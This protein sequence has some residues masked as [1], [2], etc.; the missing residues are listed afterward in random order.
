MSK[1]VLVTGHRG[2]VGRHLTRALRARGDTVVGI[3]LRAGHDAVSFFRTDCPMGTGLAGEVREPGWGA[4]K[5]TK[6]DVVVHL[7][8]LVG[9]RATIEGTPGELAARDLQLDASMFRWALALP[10]NRRPGRIVYP[11]SSAA[12]PIELQDPVK[13]PGRELSECDIELDRAREPDMSYG[14]VKLTGER[15]ANWVRTEGVPV[16]V[17]R[18][19]SGYGG[20]QDLDYPFPSFIA[21]ALRREDPF[22]VWGSGQQVRDWIHIQDVTRQLVACVDGAVPD[23]VHAVNLCTGRATTFLELA[24]LVT[25]RAGYSPQVLP[26]TYKPTGPSNRVGDPRLMRRYL[27]EPEVSLEEGIDLALRGRNDH[28]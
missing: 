13:F 21:R 20:D 22:E 6:F 8:A 4:R 23:D 28:D 18:P 16:T 14:W 10:E 25:R 24:E 7:A 19:F 15:L 5:G 3:D 11:S 1:K 12:Y 26:L 27:P 2:F 17:V 9:G